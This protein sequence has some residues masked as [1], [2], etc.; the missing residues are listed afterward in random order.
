MKITR[1]QLILHGMGLATVSTL[2]WQTYQYFQ[3]KKATIDIQ[4]PG[5]ALG[6]QIRDFHRQAKANIPPVTHANIVVIGSGAAALC[7]MWQLHKN[8]QTQLLLL[9]G[10]EKNGNNAF[11][12]YEQYRFPTGA[13]YLAMPSHESTHILDLLQDLGLYQNQQFDEM[14]LVHAPAERIWHNGVWQNDLLPVIDSDSQRFFQTVE[15]LQKAIG[16]D[17][18]PVFTI[19]IAQAS[20]DPHWLKLDNMPFAAWLKQENYHS[21]SLLWYLNYCCLDDYGQGIDAVSAWAGLQYFAARNY[22]PESTQLLTWPNG[23]GHLSTQIRQRIG[24]KEINTLDKLPDHYYYALN[25]SAMQ[26]EEHPEHVDIHCLIHGQAHIIRAKQAICAMPLYIASKVVSNI[27]QYGFDAKQHLPTY[28]PWLIGNFVLNSF[29]Q[30][31]NSTLAWDNVVYPNHGLG[32]VNSTHQAIRVAKPEKTV[33]TSY[34]ALDHMAPNEMRKWLTTASEKELI[35]LASEDLSQVYGKE[36]WWRLEHI[37]LSVRGHAMASPN[38]GYLSNAGLKALQNNH[39][40]LLFAHSD[41][42]GYSIFEEAAWHGIAAA[43]K[44]LAKL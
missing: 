7:A 12:Q 27:G 14:S 23:L 34:R 28:A 10:P 26:I 3:P 19:P 22:H 15:T 30:E 4:F 42:S 5:M 1:R 13:H 9:E 33:F 37:Q 17:Q 6:H 40:R 16:N 8:Q 38:I 24:L 35:D 29:P 2:G 11:G 36:F 32:Y 39:S 21:S 25:S 18:K 31:K 43:K 44:I 41:L 20:E